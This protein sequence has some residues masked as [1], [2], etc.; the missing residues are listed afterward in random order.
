MSVT[1]L[2]ETIEGGF[3]FW[4]TEPEEMLKLIGVLSALGNY[5]SHSVPFD[6][7]SDEQEGDGD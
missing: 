2:A 6:G 7:E 3:M 4:G 1:I 5:L